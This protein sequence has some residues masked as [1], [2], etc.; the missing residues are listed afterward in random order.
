MP[1]HI[2][3][4]DGE[5]FSNFADIALEEWRLAEQVDAL[6]QWLSGNRHRLD[7]GKKWVADI[8]FTVRPGARGGGPVIRKQL[9]EW[10]L[11]VNLEIVFSEYP[12]DA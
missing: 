9:M 5:K 2:R 12:G 11:E 7:S 1:C 3:R 6:E 4:D 10:C 8:G